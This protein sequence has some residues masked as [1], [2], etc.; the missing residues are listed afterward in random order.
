MRIKK[1]LALILTFLTLMQLCTAVCFGDGTD[2][3]VQ[4]DEKVTEENIMDKTDAR[5]AI[6]TESST[7]TVIAEKNTHEKLPVSHLAKLMTVLIAA[8]KIDS[9]QLSVKDTVTASANANAKG[10]P[11]IWLNVGE[12]ISVDELLKALTVGNA[13]DACTALAEKIGGTEDK[14][15][16]MLNRRAGELKMSDTY[17]DDVCGTSENTVSS[18]YD[19]AILA[20]EL[21]KHKFLAPYFTTWMCSVRNNATELVST[22]RL[23]RT[24]NGCQGIKSCSSKALGE[25]IVTAC[26]KGKTTLCCVILGAKSDDDKFTSARNLM[27]YGYQNYMIYTPEID[28]K[29]LENITVNYGEK[30]EIA[31]KIKGLEGIVISREDYNNMS[32]EFKREESVTA[33]VAKGDRI[34]VLTVK[35][36]DNTIV[37]MDIV[38]DETVKEISFVFAFKRLLLNLLY[39]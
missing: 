7:G 26:T 6:L 14:F 27:D 21:L 2:D 3:A 12:K 33:P 36:G 31:V 1:I 8:E 18:A 16:E 39:I 25:C 13:N 15:K 24:Y 28:E 4:A 11:Q 35:N 23:I 17:F 5:S 30:Q 19:M 37:T 34:G 10:A 32:C 22:N 20:K 29:A 9:N 38:A